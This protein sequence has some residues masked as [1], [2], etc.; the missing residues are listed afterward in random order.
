MRLAEAVRHEPETRPVARGALWH[1]LRAASNWHGCEWEQPADAGRSPAGCGG[2]PFL[3]F[4]Q[5]VNP[6]RWQMVTTRKGRFGIAAGLEV[7]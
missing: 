6:L 4:F 5:I 7:S 2:S 3:H 1:A